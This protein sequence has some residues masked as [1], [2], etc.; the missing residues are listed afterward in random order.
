MDIQEIIDRIRLVTNNCGENIRA[1]LEKDLAKLE[2]IKDNADSEILD[3]I[4]HERLPVNGGD[5]LAVAICTYLSDLEPDESE[6]NLETGWSEWVT[7]Q[8][9]VFIEQITKVIKG[10]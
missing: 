6:L 9:D 7:K 1:L 8:Y 3:K 4:L 10:E 2:A 5:N